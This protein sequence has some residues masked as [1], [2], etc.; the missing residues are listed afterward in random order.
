MAKRDNKSITTNNA[1]IAAGADD[2]YDTWDGILARYRPFDELFVYNTNQTATI[3]VQI[4]QDEEKEFYIG[5]DSSLTYDT[6][7][8]ESIAV[9]NNHGTSTI[10]AGDLIFT[11][12]KELSTDYVVKEL[13]GWMR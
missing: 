9:H 4:N 5:T 10:P 11:W 6:H 7:P 13:F 12:T 2:Y 8:V 1:A 3:S